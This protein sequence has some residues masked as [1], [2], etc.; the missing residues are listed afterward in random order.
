MMRGFLTAYLEAQFADRP[1]LIPKVVPDYP[2]GAKRVLR[3]N[4]VWAGALEARQRRPRH[5]AHPRDHRAWRGHRRRRRARRR[6][7]RLRHRL[8]GV[9][10]PDA[11]DGRRPRRCR[12]PRSVGRRRPGVPG[13]HGAGFPE[14]VLP[15]RPEHQHRDQRQHRLLLGVRGALRAGL[16]R[17]AAPR[18]PSGA[19][20]PQGRARRVQRA[21]RR[22]EPEH[23]V[24]ALVGEQLVQE[25]ERPRRPELAVHAARVL[26][27]HPAPGPRRLLVVTD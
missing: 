14:P 26:A 16:H 27:A 23:G 11:D 7:H 22:R 8:P 19:R 17:A 2:V 10:V 18:P 6:R 24:G 15:L 20:R 21:R 25:R 9:E 3:D 1:D 13:H 4:G 12:P 5:R